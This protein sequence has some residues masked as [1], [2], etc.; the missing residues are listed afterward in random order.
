MTWAS[1]QLVGPITAGGGGSPDALYLSVYT[2]IPLSHVYIPHA[3]TLTHHTHTHTH[4]HMLLQNWNAYIGKLKEMDFC[5]DPNVHSVDECANHV[6]VHNKNY[7][8]ETVGVWIEFYVGKSL[9][10]DNTHLVADLTGSD[11]KTQISSKKSV[12]YVLGG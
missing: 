12:T 11:L 7:T 4:P 3:H 8:Y 1:E 9:T 5:V 2:C 10:T 6:P